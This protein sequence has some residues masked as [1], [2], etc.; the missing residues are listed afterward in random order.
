MYHSLLGTINNVQDSEID[1]VLNENQWWKQLCLLC[2][3]LL[4]MP[5]PMPA[6]SEINDLIS[7][8]ISWL[9]PSQEVRK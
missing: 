4:Y 1:L 2:A 7:D 8:Y 9:C 5:D 6:V 3:C